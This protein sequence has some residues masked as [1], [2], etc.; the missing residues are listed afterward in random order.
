VYD[1]SVDNKS[2]FHSDDNHKRNVIWLD[3]LG[4]RLAKIYEN[5]LLIIYSI[6][7]VK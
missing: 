6:R 3:S 5:D 1:K 7:D 4:A 2:R